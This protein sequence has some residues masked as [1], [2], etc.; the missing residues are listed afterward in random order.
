MRGSSEPAPFTAAGLESK[1]T[2]QRAD[3]GGPNGEAS[4]YA[5]ASSYYYE[6]NQ[7][8]ATPEPVKLKLQSAIPLV[9]V[10]HD[11]EGRPIPNARVCA[12]RRRAARGDEHVV[13]FQGSDPIHVKTD[14]DGK[15][16]MN[17]FA[18]GDHAEIYVQQPGQKWE[19]RSLDV[20]SEGTLVV[21][22]S[23]ASN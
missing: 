9:L 10:I 5:L 3:F 21:V 14:A 16:P 15:V 6:P 22:A 8:H 11:Q 20:P 7:T 23:G 18:R 17:L 4:P 13:Y 19:T 2:T 1:S 12:S